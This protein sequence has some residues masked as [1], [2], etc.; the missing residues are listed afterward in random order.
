MIR[1]LRQRHRVMACTL[2]VVLPV[3]FVAGIAARRPVPVAASVALEVSGDTGTFA[4]VVWSKPDLWPAQRIT[5]ALRRNSSGTMAVQIRSDDLVK[6]DVLVYWSAGNIAVGESLP[7]NARL[8]GTLFNHAPLPIPAEVRGESGRFVLYS[9]ADHE[10]VVA[11][12][13]IVLQGD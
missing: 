10:V 4:Q 8:L 7:V 9:L 2:G 1:P 6:P 12:K 5:T 13:V 11:S 3:V